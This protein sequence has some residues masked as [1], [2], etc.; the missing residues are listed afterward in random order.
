MTLI[1]RLERLFKAD[2]HSILDWLEDPEAVLKQA[3]RDMEG[4][5]EKGEQMLADLSRKAAR[6]QYFVETVETQIAELGHQIDICFE[7]DNGELARTFIRKNLEAE[8]RLTTAARLVA[9]VTANKDAQQRKIDEQKEQLKTIV[10]KTQL[11]VENLCQPI[12]QEPVTT[13][14]SSHSAVSDEEVE[15]AFLHEKRNRSESESQQ[16]NNKEDNVND[17]GV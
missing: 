13:F 14:E 6:L 16:E 3:I 2:A 5:I 15:I 11:F 9:D 12:S 17:Q 10:E 4:E 1:T 7:E 8:K